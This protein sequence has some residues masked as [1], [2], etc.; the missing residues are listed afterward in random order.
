M[1]S[2]FKFTVFHGFLL[3]FLMC[4]AQ[5]A[6]SWQGPADAEYSMCIKS[7]TLPQVNKSDLVDAMISAMKIF[8][9]TNPFKKSFFRWAVQS[10]DD[11][12]D[13]CSDDADGDISMLYPGQGYYGDKDSFN[14]VLGYADYFGNVYI[15]YFDSGSGNLP[16]WVHSDTSM[17]RKN[18]SYIVYSLLHELGHAAGLDHISDVPSSMG[19]SDLVAENLSTW[20]AFIDGPMSLALSKVWKD[21]FVTNQPFIDIGLIRYKF[22]GVLKAAHSG[23]DYSIAAPTG[24]ALSETGPILEPKSI[25]LS[26]DPDKSF[27]QLDTQTNLIGKPKV[28]FPEF[29]A[30]L[31]A[32][33]AIPNSNPIPIQAEFFAG[34]TNLSLGKQVIGGIKGGTGIV[35]ARMLVSLPTDFGN[36]STIRLVLTA[37]PEKIGLIDEIDNNKVEY[38]IGLGSFNVEHEMPLLSSSDANSV[39]QYQTD[40][41]VIIKGPYQ[42]GSPLPQG[43]E[44]VALKFQRPFACD[45]V[46]RPLPVTL[47]SP[48]LTSVGEKMKSFGMDL[49]SSCEMKFWISNQGK[50]E[51]CTT[52]IAKFDPNTPVSCNAVIPASFEGDITFASELSCTNGWSSVSPSGKFSLFTK[53]KFE[54]LIGKYVIPPSD[55]KLPYGSESFVPSGSFIFQISDGGVLFAVSDSG[56]L[57]MEF[58]LVAKTG[59]FL[60][61]ECVDDTGMMKVTSVVSSCD[62]KLEILP[63]DPTA[64]QLPVDS[65]NFVKSIPN[66]WISLHEK[67]LPIGKYV[68]AASTVCGAQTKQTFGPSFSVVPQTCDK[69]LA[70]VSKPWLG[71]PEVKTFDSGVTF[72]SVKGFATSCEAMSFDFEL[73]LENA[74]YDGNSLI[75]TALFSNPSATIISPIDGY[76]NY[77]DALG[78]LGLWGKTIKMRARAVS[79]KGIPSDWIE[80]V[81]PPKIQSPDPNMPKFPPY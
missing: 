65:M 21:Y 75:S 77:L 49:T 42:P 59:G 76:I 34:T 3:V 58:N 26:S 25:P 39:L 11:S 36:F 50:S 53:E 79:A 74:P 69:N 22:A 45:G 9:S 54:T 14:N 48:P 15:H 28:I 51:T 29:S 37:M 44:I 73:K 57:N 46:P 67:Y 20:S 30:T 19:V 63:A 33:T 27:G 64:S 47:T 12:S 4:D 16:F 18:S 2:L 56:K 71:S 62:S 41:G 72:A 60:V 10:G 81:D 61:D 1:K 5:A 40:K 78:K 68:S 13:S 8:N 66:T 35:T 43:N 24:I 70:N 7:E 55:V 80:F 32:G 17:P 23:G 31:T 38:I 52:S 6:P